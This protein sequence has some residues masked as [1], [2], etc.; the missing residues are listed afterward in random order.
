M[1]EV[2]FGF[3][4]PLNDAYTVPVLLK[5]KKWYLRYS[6]DGN[7][8][9]NVQYIHSCKYRTDKYI[10]TIQIYKLTIIL[11]KELHHDH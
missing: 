8:G 9:L 4:Y 3:K 1:L 2:F 6:F 7:I 5:Y 11:R 10:T